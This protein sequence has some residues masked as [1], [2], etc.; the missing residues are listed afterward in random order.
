MGCAC[1]A[2]VPDAL[3]RQ[4][5]REAV[6]VH[7]GMEQTPDELLALRDI[8]LLPVSERY[9]HW[10]ARGHLVEEVALIQAK[11]DEVELHMAALTGSFLL[12]AIIKRMQQELPLGGTIADMLAQACEQL[13]VQDP[14]GSLVEQFTKCYKLL[15]GDG[16]EVHHAKAL[17][18][19]ETKDLATDL[20]LAVHAPFSAATPLGQLAALR[21]NKV[22]RVLKKAV[23]IQ[24]LVDSPH[25]PWLARTLAVAR[26]RMQQL[27]ALIHTKREFAPIPLVTSHLAIVQA[28]TVAALA[29]P[30]ELPHELEL[31]TVLRGEAQKRTPCSACGG[32]SNLAKAT[33]APVGLSR[34]VSQGAALRAVWCFESSLHAGAGTWDVYDDKTSALLEEARKDG[35]GAVVHVAETAGAW[36]FV[37]DLDAMV[38]TSVKTGEVRKVIRHPPR[39]EG[40]PIIATAGGAMA[41]PKGRAVAVPNGEAA[42]AAAVGPVAAEQAAAAEA[43]PRIIELARGQSFGGV[44]G[45]GWVEPKEAK[46]QARSV[47]A[48]STIKWLRSIGADF[49][50]GN[51]ETIGQID[52]RR[53]ELLQPK[54][55]AEG[56]DII[57]GGEAPG[58]AAG[59][60]TAASSNAGASATACRVCNGSGKVSHLLT[61]AQARAA[62][63]EPP[64][65]EDAFACCICMGDGAFCLSARCQ[66]AE[67][68]Y[69]CADCI[70]GTLKA[71]VDTSQFP[72]HC[73]SCRAD[74]QDGRKLDAPIDDAVLSFLEVRG[75]ISRDLTFRFAK[76][77]D[78]AAGKATRETPDNQLCPANC[79]HRLLTRH[80]SY[81]DSLL[82]DTKLGAPLPQDARGVRLGQCPCG[83]L[84]CPHCYLLVP[85]AKERAHLCEEATAVVGA[86]MTQAR[87][88]AARKLVQVEGRTDAERQMLRKF[89]KECPACGRFIEKAAGCHV[90]QCG[91]NGAHKDLNTCLRAGGC[92]HEFD[93]NTLKPMRLGKPGE[94]ANER[95]VRFKGS[96]DWL[97]FRVSR[98]M[99]APGSVVALHCKLQNR[100]ICMRNN[101]AVLG[102]APKAF[103]KLPRSWMDE[104]F[105]VVGLSDSCIALWSP[106][107]ERFVRTDQGQVDAKGGI[108]QVDQL[109]WHWKKERFTAVD[110]GDGELGLHSEN[111][112]SFLVMEADGRMHAGGPKV[113]WDRLEPAQKAD[114]RLRFRPSVIA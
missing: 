77:A 3:A 27:D 5:I 42:A 84:V 97:G 99:L 22:D 110:V 8:T 31:L 23:R 52:R 79:G 67:R 82:Y 95:Q 88:D 35:S 51:A 4:E 49:F 14:G 30:H 9:H 71:V 94:P 2:L 46:R 21:N 61:P 29:M 60:A 81:S 59:T 56:V 107:H 86:D 96:F 72:A 103:N 57:F 74:C 16:E 92:G 112:G 18:A 34:Q 13:G 63:A 65:D 75:V 55:S 66:G 105:I 11:L 28:T 12:S 114:G 73:P 43:R 20:L 108:K 39:G 33:A 109:P 32:K 50:E 25:A 64:E 100:F 91:G 68:H 7:I 47:A 41:A 98:T 113:Q 37:I 90:M 62:A 101:E 36:E 10:P 69:F 48:T 80:A 104:R 1:S 111:S 93:W 89:G 40:A 6:A 70:Q 85:P 76:A 78:L 45:S 58:S 44:Q 19:D 38:Q 17:T 54:L 53:R 15:V 26:S 106:S 102:S 24:A 87:I 83:A